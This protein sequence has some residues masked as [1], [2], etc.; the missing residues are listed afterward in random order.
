VF[1]VDATNDAVWHAWNDGSW[2]YWQDLAGVVG[3]G[4]SAASWLPDRVDVFAVGRADGVVYW[5]R[6]G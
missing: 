1:E 2:H 6:Y 3:S 5:L 4:A